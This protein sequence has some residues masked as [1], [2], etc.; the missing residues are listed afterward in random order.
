[1][2]SLVLL[3]PMLIS[4][5]FIFLLVF[6]CGLIIY[7]WRSW[8]AIPDYQPQS[9]PGASF[10]SVIIPA[11]N[12]EENIGR[13]L[14]AIDRQTL[15]RSSYEVIVID[16]HSTDR[17]AEIAMQ[18]PAVKVMSLGDSLINSYKKKAIEEGIS[19]ALGEL[20]VTTDADCLPKATWLETIARFYAETGAGFIV[21]PVEITSGRSVVEIF[22]ALDFMVLQGITGASVYK[23]FHAMCN[24]ANLAY[25]KKLFREVDGFS[26][27]DAIASG[28]DMLLMQKIA[29]KYPARIAYLKSADALVSTK[30][31]AGWSSFFNQRIRWASKA[32][33]YEDKKMFWVLFLVYAFNLSFLV[34]LVLGGWNPFYWLLLIVGLIIKIVIE[35]PFVISLSRFFEKRSVVPRYIIFQPLHIFYIVVS[36]LFG[37]FGKYEWKGRK[38]R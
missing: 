34:L 9:L 15:P 20:I 17:T 5:V 10:I 6:Y 24:G 25:E 1:M 33:K 21:S 37:Q 3:V 13:L 30:P 18:Y 19:V 27:I 11:R 32:T 8:K 16:D 4:I 12:E 29:A 7:Y 2:Q 26:G 22:Q 38:V 28:D 36:G 14:D 35:I 23:Q 31:V